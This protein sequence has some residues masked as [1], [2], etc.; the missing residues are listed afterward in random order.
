MTGGHEPELERYLHE[1][2]PISAAMGIAVREAGATTVR[3]TAPL[4]PNINHRSTVF[5]GSASA[6]AILAGWAFLH[7]HVGPGVRGSRIVIQRSS[8]DFLL[9]IRGEFEAAAHPPPAADWDRFQRVLRSRGRARVDISVT[10]T[11]NG[12]NVGQLQG[13][14]V[15]VPG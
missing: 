12:E 2:I 5:G 1:H 8:I 13:T 7:L 4:E 10:L 11:S 6:V 9:P 15:V 3:L 14:Y